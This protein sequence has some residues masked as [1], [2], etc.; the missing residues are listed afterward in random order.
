MCFSTPLAALLPGPEDG[1]GQQR[2][3]RAVQEH[4][5]PAED[6]HGLL[7]LGLGLGGGLQGEEQALKPRRRGGRRRRREEE[8]GGGDGRLARGRGRLRRQEEEEVKKKKKRSF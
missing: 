1:Q 6:Q 2:H 8:G 3:L 4:P 7:F 5:A